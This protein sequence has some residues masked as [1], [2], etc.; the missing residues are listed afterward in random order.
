MKK[1]YGLSLLPF[2]LVGLMMVPPRAKR[3]PAQAA[4]P[5]HPEGQEASAAVMGQSKTLMPDGHWLLLGGE[6][7]EGVLGTAVIEDPATGSLTSLPSGLL[8]PRAWHTATL[9]PNGKVFV[10]GGLDINDQV[11]PAAEIFDPT[12][13][14]F[15]ILTT[16]GLTPRAHQTATLLTDGSVLIAG[17]VS[18]GRQTLSSVE[19]W[20]WQGSTGAALSR[21]L[22]TPRRDH[23]AT[24]LPDGEVLFWGGSDRNGA[25]INYGEIFD[26]RTS[27]FRIETTPL[28]ANNDSPRLEESI[29]ADGSENAPVNTI[30]ALRFS[31]PLLVTTVDATTMSLSNSSGPV[32]VQVIPAEGGMLAFVTPESP[33][34]PGTSYSLTLSGL[35]DVS[36]N[37]L[38]QTTIDFTTAGTALGLN[39]GSV[40]GT[41]NDGNQ[42]LD[43]Q[44]QNFPP[45]QAPPGITAL[46]GQSL[47]LN[48]A[49]LEDL[50]IEDE[51]SGIKAATDATGR[52]LLRPLTAGHHVLFVD[53]RTAKSVGQIYGTYEI[54]I[55]VIVGKTN[56]LTYK[57]WMTPLDVVHAIRVLSPTISDMVLTTPTLP[58]LELHI[59]KGTVITDHEGKV[60]REISITPIPLSRPPFPL[61]QGVPVPIYFTI[62][63]GA[64]YLANNSG[65]G[66]RGAQLYYPNS[67]HPPGA[68]FDFWNYDPDVKGWYI[69]GHGKVSTDGKQ[70]IPDPNVRIYEFTGAMFGGGSNAPSTGPQP[71]APGPLPPDVPPG[72]PPPP[73][74]GGVPP[75]AP[76]PPGPP[77]D[78]VD[79][80]TGLFNYVKTDLVLTDVLPI[81]LTR[82]YR[83]NDSMSRAFGV[84]ATHPFDMFLV[85]DSTNYSYTELIL[86]DG[87][88]LRY[89]RISSGNS[90]ANGVFVHS[91]TTTGFYGSVIS[92]NGNGWNLS[93]KNG[94]VYV[95]P[96]GFN[97][98]SP[99]QCALIGIKDRYGNTVTFTRDTNH[100]LTQLTTPNGRWIQLTYDSSN[101]ITQAQDN[102]GRTVAYTYDSGGRL[103]TVTDAK[104]G[105]TTYTYDSNSDMLTITDPRG[106]SYL[107]NQ[108]DSNGRVIKQT[109]ADGSTYQFSYTLST[110]SSQTHFVTYGTGYSGGGPG[111][112]ILGFRN[113]EG[114][115]EGYTP[116]ISQIDIT[117]QRGYV[118]RIVF[119]GSGYAATDTYAVDRPEQQTTTYQYYADNLLK[120]VKDP[121]GR[122]TS[123]TYDVN[124]NVTQITRLSGTADAI[125]TTSTYEPAHNQVA[126]VTDPLGHTTTFDYDKHGNLVAVVDP[127]SQ[128]RSFTYNTAGQLLTVTDGLNNQTTFAYDSGDLV[129]ITNP[130][131]R[132]TNR[133]LDGAGRLITVTNPLGQSTRSDYDALNE[134]TKVT[135]PSGNATTFSYD[136]N[137]N[138]LSV[139]D[140]N[141]HTTTYTYDKMDRLLTRTDPLTNVESY[142]YDAAGNLSQFTDRRGSIATYTYDSLNRKTLAGFGTAVGTPNTYNST[143]TYSY[144]VGDRLTSVVDSVAGTIT[145]GFDK[146]DRL[147]LEQTSQ[148]AVSYTYDPAGRRTQM[149]VAGQAGINYAYDNANRLTQIAQGSAAVS[150]AY[151]AGSR[152]TSLTLPNGLVMSY[153][154]DNGSELTG[155]TYMNGSTN[156][157]SLTY[158]YDLAGRRTSM[159]GSL[160]QTALP[161]GVSEAEYNADNQL[162]E[163]GTA[164]LYYDPN[165][166]MT[167]D[168]VNSYTWNARNQ[169][170]SMNLGANSFTYDAYGRRIGKTI[171]S[172]TT[173]Y[174]YDGPNVIQ[175]LSGSSVTANLLS[176]GLDQ[177]FTRTDS[178]GTANFLTDA[179]GSTIALT[180]SS[181]STLAQYAYEPFGNTSVTSGSSTSSYEYTGRE[182]DG[183]GVYFYR[184]RYYSPAVQRFISEDPIGIAGG[185]NLYAYVSNNPVNFN[186]PFG[187]DKGGGGPGGNG[188][189][190]GDGGNGGGSPPS[191]QDYNACMQSAAS[192]LDSAISAA[193]GEQVAGGLLTLGGTVV[194]WYSFPAL[195]EAFFNEGAAGLF[196][197]AHAGGFAYFGAGGP[198]AAGIGIFGKGTWDVSNA[199]NQYYANT[200]QCAAS[201]PSNP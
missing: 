66:P 107:I 75:G 134:I 129:S 173:N 100:N 161:L 201:V 162:T 65:S 178:S 172:T 58:G 187:H 199:W 49:P 95:F 114:C 175:E 32:A 157:G 8:H 166:N 87:G 158:G 30:I 50:T 165:G 31:R 81:S 44:S 177:V 14:Q 6:G 198:L 184:G 70:V 23:T 160:A 27:T 86:P 28:Q 21:G 180:N 191:Q 101:R 12:S 113:C 174:L 106:I 96:D 13:R 60:V 183:T 82:S 38:P 105:T 17:G 52:F 85:G 55:D 112:D 1:Y 104:G 62:Q 37:P 159:G 76:P 69:Y 123:Y 137:G 15:Q 121:L 83:P 79:F 18:D 33:L 117:D 120:S 139:S 11:V 116:L 156:L 72:A 197:F 98:T 170:A 115:A 88:R 5:S 168:G 130:L 84:G 179:L 182:N 103:T 145:P 36:S 26:P 46:S 2:L 192:T 24:L 171:S 163:W 25:A 45:L 80:G 35:T 146:F 196:D 118:R 126:S 133:F 193:R 97:A 110:N 181:G 43:S 142:Q 188:G 189:D 119:N 74:P 195:G 136:G 20:N 194:A 68:P 51:N 186:D 128:E 9:L 40:L 78:P 108:Y 147:I 124:S 154:Y 10:F 138:L 111:L 16:S 92:W 41:G 152:R 151:D 164:S 200:I 153:S 59:P 190:N 127:L 144:D 47:K 135:D 122:T 91:S 73:S 61:P 149:T 48:G 22:L 29:P 54:G 167:S 63:P 4:V 39:N 56:V 99:Q 71:G 102:I 132:T 94:T 93:L 3:S 64:A 53:G 34:M 185:I 143:I 150:F 141:S 140:A 131:S 169:L 155:I 109:M 90:F 57:I 67:G 89:D 148:G 19:S 42:A 7:P 125:T 176:R 77:G